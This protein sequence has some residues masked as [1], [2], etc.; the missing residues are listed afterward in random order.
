MSIGKVMFGLV[1]IPLVLIFVVYWLGCY[2]LE[3]MKF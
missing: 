2:G 3:I 1:L